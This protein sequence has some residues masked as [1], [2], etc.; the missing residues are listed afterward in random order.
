MHTSTQTRSHLNC[1]SRCQG[2]VQVNVFHRN[3]DREKRLL[4]LQISHNYTLMHHHR[5]AQT[6]SS[7]Q[8]PSRSIDAKHLR[9][10]VHVCTHWR[11]HTNIRAR[12]HARKKAQ[13]RKSIWD[14]ETNYLNYF[15]FSLH[16][17]LLLVFL[18]SILVAFAF[19]SILV[20]GFHNT[21]LL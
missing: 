7:K 9:I 11:P 21:E 2:G 17:S 5:R 8:H 6:H 3:T 12:T 18:P 13:F 16:H 15:P 4:T 20:R 1:V 19:V 14:Q 10:H